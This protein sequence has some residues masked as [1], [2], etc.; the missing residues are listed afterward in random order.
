VPLPY[1]QQLTPVSNRESFD[2]KSRHGYLFSYC[3][4]HPGRLPLG[5][6]A[7]PSRT[8]PL[9]NAPS[10]RPA[11]VLRRSEAPFSRDPQRLFS[12]QTAIGLSLG[13]S[14]ERPQLLVIRNLP[15]YP[16]SLSSASRASLLPS[17]LLSHSPQLDACRTGHVDPPQESDSR[18]I[19]RWSWDGKNF[20]VRA[21][22]S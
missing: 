14:E 18:K 2:S 1:L 4:R 16:A 21:A 13:E 8:I 11:G 3:R 9:K 15:F 5:V 22:G 20:E 17:T 6:V 10:L 7:T 12:C 19:P